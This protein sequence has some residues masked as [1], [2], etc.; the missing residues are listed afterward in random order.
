MHVLVTGGAGF[1][2]ANLVI[3]LLD[4]G[5]DVSVIDDLSSGAEPPWRGRP[6]GPRFVQGS[7]QDDRAVRRAAR[8]VE[9][10]VHLAAKPGVADS[11]AHPEQEFATNVLGTF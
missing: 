7:I 8:G 5:Y 6:A 11:V 9:A 2:G 1:V 3:H 4:R 10:V